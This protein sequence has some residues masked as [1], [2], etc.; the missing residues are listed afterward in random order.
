MSTWL[1]VEVR[2]EGG[3]VEYLAISVGRPTNCTRNEEPSSFFTPTARTMA[4]A[5]VDP[6]R[7]RRPSLW[8]ISYRNL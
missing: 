1:A 2:V 6:V 7:Y 5:C 3:D 8:V 4:R